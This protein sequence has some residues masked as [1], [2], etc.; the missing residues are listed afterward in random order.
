M[1]LEHTCTLLTKQYGIPIYT[2]GIRDLPDSRTVVQTVDY[3][4]ELPCGEMKTFVDG[5][6]T[7]VERPTTGHT[8][9]FANDL[10]G[11]VC[12]GALDIILPSPIL[13]YR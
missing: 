1:T 6:D 3:T 10:S 11:R 2:L 12:P 13:P 7:A 4:V 5:P 9:E 8:D